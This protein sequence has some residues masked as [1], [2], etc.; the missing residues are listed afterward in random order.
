MGK[1][2]SFVSSDVVEKVGILRKFRSSSESG[3][4]ATIEKMILYEKKNNLINYKD[5]PSDKVL[6]MLFQIAGKLF[7]SVF[8][9]RL[10]CH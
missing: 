4:Y 3:Q 6:Q 9:L 10:F 7:A 2:F 1:A 5:P 8:P